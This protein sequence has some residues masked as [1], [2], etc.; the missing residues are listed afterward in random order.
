MSETAKNETVEIVAYN[1]T[2]SELL[3]RH[4]FISEDD[5]TQISLEC[6]ETVDMSTGKGEKRNAELI[7][8]V[9]DVRVNLEK[10]RKFFKADAIALGKLIDSSSK[11]IL[12][13]LQEIEKP[14][15]ERK[16]IRDEEK[17]KAKEEKE[18]IERER[19]EALNKSMSA[20]R[21]YRET[22]F[23][24]DSTYLQ[25]MINALELIDVTEALYQE[26]IEE[27]Q[28]I[29]DDSLR[30]IKALKETTLVTEQEDRDREIEKKRL[31]DERIKL[32][33]E[34]A[35][36]SKPAPSIVEKVKTFVSEIGERPDDSHPR[37]QIDLPGEPD[38]L[39]ER[40]LSRPSDGPD[41]GELIVPFDKLPVTTRPECI[42]DLWEAI[43]DEEAL[44]Y[45]ETLES[46]C[47]YLE[48]IT[49]S[50]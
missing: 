6:L 4:G 23:G 34:K 14:L 38:D 41:S 35:E 22:C 43:Q 37:E 12:S 20:L 21:E 28:F 24:Q 42:I 3:R 47:D 26:K 33:S 29:K 39:L 19:V 44:K 17:Q 49:K 36:A 18:R 10:G 50:V 25:G 15:V 1:P 45:V 27:A 31:E 40:C 16:T 13:Q 32:E 46:Y 9:R 11:E 30:I 8:L 7:K 48:I 2:D 5:I